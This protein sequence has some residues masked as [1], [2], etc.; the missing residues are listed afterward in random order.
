MPKDQPV[1]HDIVAS[2]VVFHGKIWDIA[3]ESFEYPGGRLVR[4]FVKH[5]GAVA[6]IALNERDE[7]RMIRQY[8]H[9]VR[10]NLWEIPAG[11]L[12]MP[13]E[14]RLEAAKRELLEETSLE[15]DN[16]QHLIDF[17]T[18]PGGNDELISIF[19]ATDLREVDSGFEREGEERDML[20]EWIPLV[21]AVRSVLASEIKSP[22]AAIG[23]QALALKRG[24][25][26]G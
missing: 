3:R 7:V 18:T 6:I 9:P 11:L 15:A 4:E 19:L 23:L 14:N 24:I 8:R 16:W 13:G 10:E 12:D 21:E 22:S 17:Y 2:E 26:L 25:S 1:A 5:P 20:V